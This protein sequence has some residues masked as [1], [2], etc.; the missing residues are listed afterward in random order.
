MGGSHIPC[1]RFGRKSFALSGIETPEH[2]ACSLVTIPTELP[3]LLH[4][5]AAKPN[6]SVSHRIHVNLCQ[7]RELH[8]VVTLQIGIQRYPVVLVSA[9]SAESSRDIPF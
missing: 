8:V 7:T 5:G 1:G 2:L 6:Q 9:K 3:R 4:E